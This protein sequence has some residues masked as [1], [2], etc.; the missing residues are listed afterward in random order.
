MVGLS[1]KS[2]PRTW[3][4]VHARTGAFSDCTTTLYIAAHRKST[5]ENEK[6]KTNFKNDEPCP[7]NEI[8]PILS[9]TQPLLR[10]PHHDRQLLITTL[11]RNYALTTVIVFEIFPTGLVVG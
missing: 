7:I 10:V 11:F 4:G 9:I 6:T 3:N 5:V 1:E 8:S 2:E